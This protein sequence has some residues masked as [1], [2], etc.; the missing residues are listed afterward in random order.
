MPR[1]VPQNESEENSYRWTAGLD[2]TDI[3]HNE[4]MFDEKVMGLSI[5]REIQDHCL[6][7]TPVYFRGGSKYPDVLELLNIQLSSGK[8]VR[9]LVRHLRVY[10]R[11]ERFQTEIR[12]VRDT[13]SI[14]PINNLFT[15]AQLELELY[16]TYAGRLDAVASLPFKD[17]KIRLEICVFHNHVWYTGIEETERVKHNFFNTVRQAYGRAK[18]AGANVCVRWEDVETGVRVD[19]NEL[20]D[21]DALNSGEVSSNEGKQKHD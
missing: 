8:H 12:Q 3:F 21:I 19:A 5:S 14:F 9:E 10:L 6:R 20:Y 18:G 11:L 17:H 15:D 7:T 16:K 1:I 13:P 4:Y 2:A